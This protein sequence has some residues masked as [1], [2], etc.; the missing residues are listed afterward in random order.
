MQEE[1]NLFKE[2]YFSKGREAKRR[3]LRIED[4][5]VMLFVAT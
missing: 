1:E 2:S 3:N 5:G 4:C